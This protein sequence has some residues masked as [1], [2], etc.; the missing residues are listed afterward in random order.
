MDF[1]EKTIG[2]ARPFQALQR[3]KRVK[4]RAGIVE[5][6]F[7]LQSKLK[8]EVYLNATYIFFKCVTVKCAIF[9][10]EV[11]HSVN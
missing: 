8:N 1:P 6:I 11:C 5:S 3:A 7:V 9:L 4:I 10:I 2:P